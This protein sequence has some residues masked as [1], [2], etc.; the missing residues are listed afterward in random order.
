[1]R[2]QVTENEWSSRVIHSWVIE[3]K[4]GPAMLGAR[5]VR[6]ELSAA[7]AGC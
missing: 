1:M 4:T 2:V 7:D 5:L 3:A 6:Q